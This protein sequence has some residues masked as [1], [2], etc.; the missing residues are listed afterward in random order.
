M[1]HFKKTVF[2]LTLVTVTFINIYSALAADNTV[3]SEFSH[4]ESTYINENR[5]VNIVITDNRAPIEYFDSHGNPKGIAVDIYKLIENRTGLNFHFFKENNL[6]D[7]LN[8]VNA[9]KA[10][11]ISCVPEKYAKA[12]YPQYITSE[13]F[14]SIKNSLFINTDTDTSD[15]TNKTLAVVAGSIVPENTYDNRIIYYDN[16]EECLRAVE[17]GK[18]DYGYYDEYPVNLTVINNK[19]KN[20]TVVPDKDTADNYCLLYTNNQETLR[21]I[22]NKALA[23]ITDSDMDSIILEDQVAASTSP[24]YRRILYVYRKEVTL[25]LAAAG[26][27]TFILHVISIRRRIIR[28]RETRKLLSLSQM[29]DDYIVEYNITR[30][31]LKLPNKLK[32]VLEDIVKM[33]S[34][35][36]YW[37]KIDS[38]SKNITVKQALKKFLLPC[39]SSDEITVTYIDGSVKNFSVL[40]SELNIGRKKDRVKLFKINDISE[41]AAEKRLLIEKSR[42]DAMTGLYN[43][44]YFKRIA[45]E[46][47]EAKEKSERGFLIILDIDKF[48]DINDKYGHPAGD[49][50]I[51]TLALILKKI[52]RTSDIIGR[53]GGDEFCV[54]MHGSLSTEIPRKKILLLQKQLESEDSLTSKYGVTISAGIIEV[55][56]EE[57]FNFLYERVDKAL[58][59]AKE[60]GRND[61]CYYLNSKAID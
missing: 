34:G 23:S 2:I 49:D 33:K 57:T 30:G 58:Y 53:M 48:K 51:T 11:I 56:P 21:G 41:E 25:I 20:L 27:I 16:I 46:M 5:D 45:S 6:D 12:Y 60:N 55:N 44:E 28:E 19:Y 17:N 43:S 13:G 1:L 61:L 15:M 3:L 31:S 7:A 32:D 29:S 36:F 24:S 4:E 52:F 39:E 35:C 14:M 38:E 54:Y 50:V 37:S 26:L 10:D 18:A 40:C 42:L 22:I 47:I 8:N 9:I 59:K